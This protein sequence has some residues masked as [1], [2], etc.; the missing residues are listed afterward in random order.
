MENTK[1]PFGVYWKDLGGGKGGG[2]SE[3]KR[4]RRRYQNQLN[5]KKLGGDTR[6]VAWK[7]RDLPVQ[8]KFGNL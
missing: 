8:Q 4:S 6:D 2:N 3:G 5:E 1:A 7:A